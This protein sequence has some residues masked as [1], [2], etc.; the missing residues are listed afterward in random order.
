VY[1]LKLMFE[2]GGGTIWCDNDEARDR[3]DVGPIEDRL[4]LSKETLRELERLSTKH[5]EALNWEYPAGPSKWAKDKIDEFDISAHKVLKKVKEELGS[6]FSIEY[7]R[8]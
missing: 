4:P 2:W 3:F 1:K 5:D 6:D 7:I 8:L